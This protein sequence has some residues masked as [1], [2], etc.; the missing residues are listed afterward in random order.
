MVYHTEL[1]RHW[2]VFHLIATKA[3]IST[4]QAASDG[5]SLSNCQY[6]FGS[7]ARNDVAIGDGEAGGRVEQHSF[8][9]ATDWRSALPPS[10]T[11]EPAGWRRPGHASTSQ[12]SLA[13]DERFLLQLYR[14]DNVERQ[15]RAEWGLVCISASRS[16]VCP[17]KNAAV[18]VWVFGGGFHFQKVNPGSLRPENPRLRRE[19][20]L[21]FDPILASL[22]YL[23]STFRPTGRAGTIFFSKIF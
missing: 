17:L 12:L 10:E 9:P 5:Q 1:R 8:R 14:I 7:P 20:P 15:H 18:M 19:P 3:L 23:L 2:S 4:A 13:D 16:F 6:A 11:D 22:G 21:R